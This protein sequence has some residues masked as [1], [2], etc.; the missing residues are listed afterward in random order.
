MKSWVEKITRYFLGADVFISYAR[1]DSYR[2]AGNLAAQLA[3]RGLR[4]YVDQNGTP[5]GSQVPKRIL[6]AASRSSVL[7][8]LISPSAFNSR[9]VKEEIAAFPHDIRPVIP[10]LFS[11]TPATAQQITQA[12]FF[13]MIEGMAIAP[14]SLDNL[15]TGKPATD[16]LERITN[17]VGNHR[18]NLRL[19]RAGIVTSLI[20]LVGFILL[21]VTMHRLNAASKDLI[22]QMGN[23][24]KT[25]TQLSAVEDQLAAKSVDLRKLEDQI[26]AQRALVEKERKRADLQKRTTAK[27]WDELQEGIQ[28]SYL[29][30]D[31]S[32]QDG[33][34]D[35]N[36]P[37]SIYIPADKFQVTQEGRELLD[38]FIRCYLIQKEYPRILISGH[39]AHIAPQEQKIQGISIEGSVGTTSHEYGLALAQR[40][41]DGIRKYLIAAGIPSNKIATMSFGRERNPHPIA[42]MNNRVEVRVEFDKY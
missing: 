30:P 15:H 31:L 34:I 4:P 20:V 1:S 10:V 2:Y 6:K 16:L 36:Q 11:T 37:L 9:A 28:L 35:V 41:A 26:T 39:I 17:A 33:R 42:L 32:C 22:E 27:V 23:L 29:Q 19:K 18:Q 38:A 24:T 3:S 7:V 21:G 13:K 25:K 40:S 12:A 14:E 8:A 5:P